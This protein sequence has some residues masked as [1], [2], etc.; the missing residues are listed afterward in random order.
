MTNSTPKKQQYPLMSEW[1][2]QN[3]NFLLNADH[4]TLMEWYD[5]ASVD[6]LLYAQQLFQAKT[7]ELI[8]E[9]IELLDSVY[10]VRYAILANA[11][12]NEVKC[13]SVR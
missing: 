1:D 7:T 4:N 3:L 2:K 11:I 9:E 8:L 12:I 10:D 6:D 5:S 13:R